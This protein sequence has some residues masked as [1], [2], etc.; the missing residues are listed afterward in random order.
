LWNHLRHPFVFLDFNLCNLLVPH[1]GR[2]GVDVLCVDGYGVV[3]WNPVSGALEV[4]DFAVAGWGDRFG[5][6]LPDRFGSN[7]KGRRQ[8]GQ[9]PDGA[10]I[11]RATS[12][13]AG[14]YSDAIHIFE[15]ASAM[16]P[17]GGGKNAG[18]Q[19]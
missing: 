6:S 2:T 19:P 9:S 1:A 14:E 16:T 7:V 11:Y 4:T 18:P 3:V 10:H 8:V 17:V 5:N 12:L 13:L 15:R